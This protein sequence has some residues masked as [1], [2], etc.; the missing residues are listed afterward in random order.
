MPIGILGALIICT[1]LYIMTSAVLV[2]IVPYQSLDN[3]API[4]IAVNHIGLPWFAVLVKLGAIAGLSSVMLVLMYGQTRIFYTMSRDGLLPKFISTVHARF[5]T[6]WINTILVGCLAAGFAGFRS[7]DDLSDLSNVG[8][9]AAFALVCLTVIYLRFANPGLERP[10]RAPLFFVTAPL[11]AAMCIFLLMS[12]MAG[13]TTRNFFI[14]YLVVGILV[15]F[16]Y[17]FWFSKL[18]RGEVVTGHEA[19]PMELPHVGD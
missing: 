19:A 5:K 15:Y 17:G 16:V 3:P 1:V 4:A 9:L 18:N 12:L 11:G 13:A 7:L 10:F 2:G 14:G 6:P 8:S